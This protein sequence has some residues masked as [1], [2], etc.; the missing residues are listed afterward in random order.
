MAAEDGTAALQP[1]PTP[2]MAG[3]SWG[4]RLPSPRDLG[5][6]GNKPSWAPCPQK[7]RW[8]KAVAGRCRAEAS[9]G[10]Q[11]SGEGASGSSITADTVL[12]VPASSHFR[13][14]L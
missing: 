4:W 14:D 11:P 6:S 13:S 1:L 8:Q 5:T 10:A 12:A 3:P 2:G 7:S 9:R